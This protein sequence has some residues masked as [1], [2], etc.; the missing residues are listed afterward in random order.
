M[1]FEAIVST[2]IFT[3]SRLEDIRSF[4]QSSNIIWFNIL[5]DHTVYFLRIGLKVETRELVPGQCS[6][7]GKRQWCLDLGQVVDYF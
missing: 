6:N 4:Q 5:K 3:F 2:F 1:H 7:G